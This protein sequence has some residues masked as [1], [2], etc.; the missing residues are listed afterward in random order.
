MQYKP[1]SKNTY[2]SSASD[3]M[4]TDFTPGAEETNFL[5]KYGA[6]YEISI[7]FIISALLLLPKSEAVFIVYL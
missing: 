2:T 7:Y 3:I 6:N 1:K 5:S 4:F